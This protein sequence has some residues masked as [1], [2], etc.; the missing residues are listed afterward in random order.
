[1]LVC[2]GFLSILSKLFPPS[3]DDAM[4]LSMT[5]GGDCGVLAALYLVFSSL[6]IVNEKQEKETSIVREPG[7]GGLSVVIWWGAGGK[8][9]VS[10]S[11]MPPGCHQ[12]S[13]TGS[14][15]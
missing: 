1:M 5:L 15:N 11:P 3:D 14:Y 13:P 12:C 7:A 10:M 4:L 8:V 2:I 9:G 6:S